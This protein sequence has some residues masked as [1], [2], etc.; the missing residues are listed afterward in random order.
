[1]VDGAARITSV[2]FDRLYDFLDGLQAGGYTIDPRQ[3]MALSDLLMALIARGEPLD[4]LSLKT[5]IAPLICTSPAE[6]HDFYRQFDLWYPTFFPEQQAQVQEETGR[7]SLPKQAQKRGLPSI[8]RTALLGVVGAVALAA[9][10]IGLVSNSVVTGFQVNNTVLL[11]GAGAACV[12]LFGWVGWR[13]WTLYQENQY[14][15]RQMADQE[16]V[17]TRVP[18]K[19]YLQEIV[20]VMQFKPLVSALRRRVQALSGEV[21]VDRTIEATLQKGKWPQVVHRQQQIMPEYV[22]LIDRK[23]RLDQQARFVQEVLHRLSADGV[24]LHQYEFNGDPRICFPL[25]HREAPLYLKDLHAR[26]PDSRLLIFSGKGEFINPIS[27]RLQIWLEALSDWQ[28][29]AIITPDRI[30]KG[31]REKLQ[32]RDFAVL[33]MTM[34]GLASLV[35]VFELDKA[36]LLYASPR[37]VPA[38]LV[39]RPLLWTGRDAPPVE[40]LDALMLDLKNYLG[41]NGLY[42][43]RALAV[44]PELRWELTLFL[45]SAL[46]DDRG[47]PLLDPDLLLRLARLP[48][49]RLGY[50]P[51]WLR[52][53]L[54]GGF[55][56]QQETG[57]HI[58][59]GELFSLAYKG[60]DFDLTFSRSPGD[61]MR[62]RMRRF[63]N[64]IVR[65][66][67]SESPLKDYIFI[68][69]I[70]SNTLKRLAVQFPKAWRQLRNTG[71]QELADVFLMDLVIDQETRK[72]TPLAIF[73]DRYLPMRIEKDSVLT[74]RQHW[75]I[76]LKSLKWL[77]WLSQATILV[78]IILAFAFSV[79]G[80]QIS[81]WT[82][83]G[84]LGLMNFPLSMW[85]IYEYQAWSGKF[86][87]ITADKIQFVHTQPLGRDERM[88][89]P[90]ENIHDIQVRNT[91]GLPVQFESGSINIPVGAQQ[92]IFENVSEPG[93]IKLELETRIL[94]N[95]Q[96]RQKTTEN[97]SP[98]VG[99]ANFS[100]V[101]RDSNEK[102]EAVT[103]VRIPDR[104]TFGSLFRLR[105]EEGNVIIYRKHRLA[106][107]FSNRPLIRFFDFKNLPLDLYQITPSQ[108]VSL[109][110][111]PSGEERIE[112]ARL[113]DLLATEYQRHGFWQSL[114]N[115]GDIILTLDGRKI[116]LKDVSDPARAQAD[117]N[118]RRVQKFQRVKKTRATENEDVEDDSQGAATLNNKTR[119]N[120]DGKF[121]RTDAKTKSGP[122]RVFISYNPLDKPAA[123]RMHEKLAAKEWISPWLDV[124]NLL[125]GQDMDL[126]IY[127]ALR[128]AQVILICLSQASVAKKGYLNKDIRRVLDVFDERLEGSVFIIPIR[129]DDFDA[130]PSGRLRKLQWLDYFAPDGHEQLLKSLRRRAEKLDIAVDD[131]QTDF[132]DKLQTSLKS[133]G[134]TYGNEQASSG[135]QI[136]I[137][138]QMAHAYK[139]NKISKSPPE[140]QISLFHATLLKME[141]LLDIADPQSL[142]QSSIE[143]IRDDLLEIIHF[144]K[145]LRGTSSHS[146][147]ISVDGVSESLRLAENDLQAAPNEK[148]QSEFI[149]R[150]Q[151]ARLN[152][153]RAVEYFDASAVFSPRNF[154]TMLADEIASLDDFYKNMTKEYDASV[155]ELFEERFMALRNKFRSMLSDTSD[156]NYEFINRSQIRKEQV[157]RIIN[158][159]TEVGF[160]FQEARETNRLDRPRT[161]DGIEDLISSIKNLHNAINESLIK[162]SRL[163]DKDNKKN[164][165]M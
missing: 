152:I 17:Y 106:L 73:F 58:A 34:A 97:E 83:L 59:L 85:L 19:A 90:F 101:T 159:S 32:A 48:W 82:W 69:F 127:E 26:F 126:E 103:T 63:L 52:L 129:L 41:E 119:F 113:E 80:R 150:M 66:S 122:L 116:I 88:S 38:P 143:A 5:L 36:P 94:A 47:Q 35:R 146:L 29:R 15:T 98:V 78:T 96:G 77:P 42:W 158:N 104:M 62:E 12:G 141:E 2:N 33:P 65:N 144:L 92:I 138:E 133:P 70:A 153:A 13:L 93:Q 125:P 142:T 44:Y 25:G 72:K 75:Y 114:F 130:L 60:E 132:P 118:L 148:R 79:L 53:V 120:K 45:G 28:E 135:Y 111:E 147:V 37:L 91:G 95:R 86:L 27:G 124:E 87:Q 64:A 22:V 56:P 31:L 84:A 117:I 128:E 105:Y 21:D 7:V 149:S 11:F 49:F 1:M 3:I 68:R 161:S 74:Y 6:Q 151:S 16:P 160:H 99:S 137:L 157:K 165:T 50:L 24:W 134:P 43:L 112:T 4:D 115:Y 162:E 40:A 39:E 140:E 164:N 46:R 109:H 110:R 131:D 100:Q 14:I 8:N 155:Y 156:P 55:T 20:P 67:P 23:S 61:S 163:T 107:L 57:V 18:I 30:H 51:D 121:F 10:I 145:N 76:L 108:V 89:S 136:S 71:P 81:I 102:E 54:V 154:L 123:L 139:I 9:F